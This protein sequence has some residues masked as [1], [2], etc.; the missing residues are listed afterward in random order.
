M[1]LTDEW[2]S[3]APKTYKN[4]HRYFYVKTSAFTPCWG[5]DEVES[6]IGQ[7]TRTFKSGS[8]GGVGEHTYRRIIR[9]DHSFEGHWA[10]RGGVWETHSKLV[11]HLGQCPNCTY[12]KI[13][14]DLMQIASLWIH[15]EEGFDE[16]S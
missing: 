2:L 14:D 9:L 1:C 10:D 12:E 4:N 6:E 16:S 13:C 15:E 3:R 5:C 7:F 11:T 8:H